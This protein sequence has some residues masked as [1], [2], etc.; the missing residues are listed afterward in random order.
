M[1]QLQFNAQGLIPVVTQ[2]IN[3]NEVLMLAYMN[4]E[5]FDQTL[6]T[7]KATYYSRSRQKLWVKGEES[8]HTQYV[9]EIR[10]DCDEDAILLKVEQIGPACHT[11]NK[12]CFYRSVLENEQ[13]YDKDILNTLES[14]LKDRLENPLEGSY[15]TY[16]FNKGVDKIL[17]KVAEESGE[18]LIA[19]KNNN[20][21]LVYEVSDLFYH[22]LVLMVNQGLDLNDIYKELSSRRK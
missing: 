14:V 21:E 16:L 7:K 19:A 20:D 2:D 8:G 18:V 22:L 6:L 1:I 17:K 13:P 3:T 10:Y 12:S 11:N 15:T 9:K 5:A 4:Q